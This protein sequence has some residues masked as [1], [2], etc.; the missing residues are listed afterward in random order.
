MPLM[1]RGM[2]HSKSCHYI[3]M[4][5]PH[6]G[7]GASLKLSILNPKGRIWTMVAGG[8]ELISNSP[9]AVNVWADTYAS[10]V[11]CAW[12]TRSVISLQC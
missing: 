7:S 11:Q 3:P 6:V 9:L 2:S 12:Q 4:A 1:Q 5:I 10:F 8:G